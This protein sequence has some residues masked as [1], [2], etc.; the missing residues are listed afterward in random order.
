MT[1]SEVRQVTKW[2]GNDIQVHHLIGPLVAGN[3][4]RFWLV[5]ASFNGKVISD[6]QDNYY[7]VCW[8]P[9]TA[10]WGWEPTGGSEVCYAVADAIQIL[11]RKVLP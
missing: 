2:C 3:E 7:V 4:A 1:E 5:R 9:T 6:T 8:E 11:L 10:D